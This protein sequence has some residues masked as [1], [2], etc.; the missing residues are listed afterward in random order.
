MIKRSILIVEYGVRLYKEMIQ[1]VVPFVHD[2]QVPV[3]HNTWFRVVPLLYEIHPSGVIT[4]LGARFRLQ[5][6][7][8]VLCLRQ[9]TGM[10]RG[11]VSA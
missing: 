6:E 2:N 1:R 5:N 7:V 11:S 8:C 10:V 9:M 4:E 3:L